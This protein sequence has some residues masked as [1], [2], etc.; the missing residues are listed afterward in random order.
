MRITSA[1]AN[2]LT[3]GQL[4]SFLSLLQ[5]AVTDFLFFGFEFVAS[6]VSAPPILSLAAALARARL[7]LSGGLSGANYA[8]ALGAGF[9]DPRQKCVCVP[10]FGG[11]FCRKDINECLSRPCYN[12]GRCINEM[13]S[14]RCECQPGFSGESCFA[15]LKKKSFFLQNTRLQQVLQF[16]EKCFIVSRQAV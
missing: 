12:G 14:F 10:G 4:S 15:C 13:G 1:A 16:R 3:F 11:P 9:A 5:Y 6:V 2:E 8:D 7:G